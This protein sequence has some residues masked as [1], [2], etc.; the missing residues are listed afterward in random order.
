MPK[1]K[2][3]IEGIKAELSI[4]DL[5][6][7]RSNPQ[8]PLRFKRASLGGAEFYDAEIDFQIESPQSILIEKGEFKW[9]DGT[10]DLE[11]MRIS[12]GV[13]A[14]D[15]TLFCN[16]LKLSMIL[17]QFGLKK[18]MGKGTVNGRIPLRFSKGEVRFEDAFLYSTPGDGGTIRLTGAEFLTSGIPPNSPEFAQ[19]ALAREALKDYDYDWVKLRLITEGEDLLL[20]LQL[21]GK[22]TRPLPFVYQK[23]SGGFVKVEAGSRGSVFQGIRLDINF[24]FPLNELL[25]YTEAF[26]DMTEMLK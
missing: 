16:R 3:L 26:G 6:R 11:A 19:L 12:P 10:V 14:Y 8:Q 7:V 2:I 20:Q 17:E 24:R 15:L 18:A 9:C 25:F 23:E 22:P 13:E 5:G 21:D 4:P 1:T